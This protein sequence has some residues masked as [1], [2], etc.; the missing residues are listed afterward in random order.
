MKAEMFIFKVVFYAVHLH[1]YDTVKSIQ[2]LVLQRQMCLCIQFFSEKN[3]A[4]IK[5]AENSI[6]TNFNN[7]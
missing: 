4:L 5:F 3:I 6:K 1:S 7:K 2:L